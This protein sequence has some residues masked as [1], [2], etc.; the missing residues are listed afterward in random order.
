MAR[1]LKKYGP[2]FFPAIRALSQKFGSLSTHSIG[3]THTT[4][5]TN[6]IR[7][8]EK[9]ESCGFD[10]FLNLCLVFIQAILPEKS[11]HIAPVSV[12]TS[13]TVVAIMV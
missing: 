13:E 3:S 4:Q 9:V 8:C 2:L 7:Y 1:A 12:A 10:Y 6:E 5:L 11:E